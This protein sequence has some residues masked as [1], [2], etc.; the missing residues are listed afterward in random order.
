[1][2][3]AILDTF[4]F[5]VGRMHLRSRNAVLRQ[6]QHVAMP[7]VHRKRG[8]SG[9]SKSIKME[10]KTEAMESLN[11][12]AEENSGFKEEQL[13]VVVVPAMKLE[14]VETGS[15]VKDEEP[16]VGI[17]TDD[18]ANS[19]KM[20]K[21]S[22][23]AHAPVN[24]KAMWDGIAGMRAEKSAAVDAQGCETFNDMTL[25][26]PVRRFHVLVACM[27]SSQTKDPVTAAAM[28][29]LRAHGLTVESMLAIKQAD[30]A[31]MLRP[32]GFF[33]NKAKY[34]QQTCATLQ[35]LYQSDIPSTY[36]GL[37]ALPGV[38]PKMATLTMSCAWNKDLRRHPRASDCQPPGVGKDMGQRRQEPG[39]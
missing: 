39:S 20:V 21:K 2:A 13:G 28:G 10:V 29:R 30:L 25:D 14:V 38:G 31:A 12:K 8:A 5:R 24:W 3:I 32:V 27:L 22:K 16:T 35:S 17:K 33:N 34:I 18:E 6:T 7:A 19:R 9:T 26:P 4:F 23:H 1:M 37:V 36:E 11:P 15:F